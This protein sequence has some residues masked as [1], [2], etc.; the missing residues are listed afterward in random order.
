MLSLLAALTFNLPAL[1]LPRVVPLAEAALGDQPVS[2]TAVANERSP[3]GLHDFSS[4]G[5]YWWPAPRNLAGPY[6]R[7]D[8][9]TNPDNFVAHWGLMFA[10]ARGFGALAAAYASRA[11]NAFDIEYAFGTGFSKGYPRRV[12]LRYSLLFR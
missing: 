10:F 8:G 12:I 5:D 3:G 6:I 2:I 4:E 9:E 11:K 1:K 7:R